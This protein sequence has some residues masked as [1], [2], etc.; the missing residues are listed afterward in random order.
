MEEIGDS[1]LVDEMKLVE[2][3]TIEFERNLDQFKKTLDFEEDRLTK[4]TMKRENLQKEIDSMY[5]DILME[6]EKYRKTIENVIEE[7]EKIAEEC[8]INLTENVS[9]LSLI[10]KCES[11][12]E[13]SKEIN[14]N[15]DVDIEKIRCDLMENYISA[16]E[17]FLTT[18][19]NQIQQQKKK[20]SFD[21]PTL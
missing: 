13:A 4:L 17:D 6:K 10:E 3:K 15:I 20:L 2:N 7:R 14:Y 8:H 11:K 9:S 5:Q 12:V 16:K 1:P 21:N 19:K 18:M